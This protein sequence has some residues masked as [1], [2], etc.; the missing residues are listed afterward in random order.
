MTPTI[1]LQ[2]KPISRYLDAGIRLGILLTKA[3]FRGGFAPA[4]FENEE[5]V[6]QNLSARP[7]K[8]L[9]QRCNGDQREAETRYLAKKSS[10]FHVNSVNL[11][12]GSEGIQPGFVSEVNLAQF[13]EDEDDIK[14]AFHLAQDRALLKDVPL[15]FFD[16]FDSRD[17]HF[18][19]VLFGTDA[20]RNFQGRSF[21]LSY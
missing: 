17:L 16:E 8:L 11:P 10:E 4:G 1:I 9:F 13:G 15:I 5:N 6:T 7:F 3:H 18:F 20:G 21:N 19:K 2:S 14:S 12:I